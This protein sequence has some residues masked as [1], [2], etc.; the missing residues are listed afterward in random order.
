MTVAELRQF[1][2]SLAA[3]LDSAGGKQVAHDLRRAADGL[4]PFA[5]LSVTAFADFLARAKQFAE[6]G[7]VPGK[8]GRATKAKVIDDEAI[9]A[10]A[11]SYQRLYDRCTDPAVGETE[12]ATQMKAL[13]KLSKDAL[14][15]LART[16]GIQKTL[17]T[18]KDAAAELR[19]RI[20]DRRA[21]FERVGLGADAVP[22]S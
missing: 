6:T 21:T 2:N 9:H 12:I 7:V 15:A 19:R 1:L 10:A 8:A 22:A 4:A 13:E 3:P 16:V 17:K 5:S 11:A 14:I 18:K 20:S